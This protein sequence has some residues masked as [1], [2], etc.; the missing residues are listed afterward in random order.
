MP[1]VSSRLARSDPVTASQIGG[2]HV[3]RLDG[4]DGLSSRQKSLAFFTLVIALVLEIVDVTIVNTALPSIQA[5]FGGGSA[6]TA[7]WIVAGYSLP[8]S[9]LL[10]L[11]GRLGD[12]FGSRRMFLLGVAGFTAASI[13]CGVA[14]SGR[15]LVAARILQGACGAVMAPQV[16]S[17]MQL[18]Y[19]P[20]ERIARLSWFGIIGGLSAISGPIIGGLLIA[21]NIGGLGWRTVFLI[22]GPIGIAALL[23]GLLLLPKSPP[24]PDVRIDAVGTTTFAVAIAALLFPLVRGEG[25]RFGVIDTLLLLCGMVLSAFAWSSLKRRAALG[26]PTIFDPAVMSNRLFR[27]GIGVLLT[28]SAANTGFLFIFAYALQHLAHRT[29]LQ[30]GLIHIPFTVGVMIGMGL[31]GRHLAVRAEKWILVLGASVI[32]IFGGASLVWI[33]A[34]TWPLSILLPMLMVAGMGMGMCSGPATPMI[35]A[36]VEPGQ[37]GSASG[38][39]KTVQQMGGAFGVALV[40]G[41]FFAQDAGRSLIGV[42]AVVAILLL[43][44][45]ILAATLPQHIFSQQSSRRP[46]TGPGSYPV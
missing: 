36:W 27:S 22:N 7:Q 34:G 11:G 6:A 46:L 8:F 12:V 30:T 40:G 25:T 38:I 39:V 37:A 23:A 20:V 10:I 29:P 21:A 43:S 35:L 26:R 4:L 13:A 1:S 3:V 18:L 31:I 33:E 42:I 45:A 44:C 5:D 9:L 15:L 16:L 32:A 2:E 17:M 19:T 28:F 41:A 14:P 24:R